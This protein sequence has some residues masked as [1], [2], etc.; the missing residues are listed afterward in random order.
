MTVL[1]I[2]ISEERKFQVKCNDAEMYGSYI[3]LDVEIAN[4]T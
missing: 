2:G 1:C 4:F 3:I